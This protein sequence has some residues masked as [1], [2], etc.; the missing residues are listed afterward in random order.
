MITEIVVNERL[1]FQLSTFMFR[2]SKIDFFI[3]VYFIACT[4]SIIILDIII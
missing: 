3:L 1:V 2:Y 4:Y